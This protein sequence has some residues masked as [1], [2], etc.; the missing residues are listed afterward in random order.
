M[1][2]ESDSR[3][4]LIARGPP[5]VVGVLLIMRTDSAIP[6][7]GRKAD[8][9]RPLAAYSALNAES[10]DQWTISAPTMATRTCDR[11][12]LARRSESTCSIRPHRGCVTTERRKSGKK[13]LL[14]SSKASERG[15]PC[16]CTSRKR[17]S[18]PKLP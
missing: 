11:S 12:I 4:K 7:D 15:L 13:M 16:G 17:N 2:S 3:V 9:R 1:P 14:L 8:A 5:S 6:Q 18:E 10:V